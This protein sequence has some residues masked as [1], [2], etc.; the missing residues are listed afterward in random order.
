MKMSAGERLAGLLRTADQRLGLFSPRGAALYARLAPHWNRGLY[1][2][3]AG[4]VIALISPSDRAAVLDLGCGAGSLLV[5]LAARL[6][7]ATLA[8]VDVSPRMLESAEF[9]AQR[10]GVGSRTS[11]HGADAAALP[12]DAASFDLVVSTLSLHHW[13]DPRSA[14]AEIGRVLRIG[15]TALLYD[16]RA[17]AYSRR[18]LERLLP[19]GLVLNSRDSVRAGRLPFAYYA[20]LTL[21]RAK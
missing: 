2:R 8:G 20:R 11:F 19:P 18:E 13:R 16:P 4:D 6:P 3:V 1:E 10:A 9:A 17:V 5:V 14:F 7:V 21:R 15:G 12:F